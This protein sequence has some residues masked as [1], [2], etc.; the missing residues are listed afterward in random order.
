MRDNERPGRVRGKKTPE[1][2]AEICSLLNEDRRSLLLTVAK[3]FDVA[4]GTADKIVHDDLNMHRVC[5]KLE[6]VQ[7]FPQ[8]NNKYKI[9]PRRLGCRFEF[10]LAGH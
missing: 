8:D 1:Y 3:S 6:Q 10:Q 9:F 2:V 7:N 5:A 4:G